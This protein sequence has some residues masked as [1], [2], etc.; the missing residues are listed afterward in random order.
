MKYEL[1]GFWRGGTRLQFFTLLILGAVCIRLAAFKEPPTNPFEG[2]RRFLFVQDV[3]NGQMAAI[4]LHAELVPAAN[5]ALEAADIARA[6]LEDAGAVYDL[7][8][9]LHGTLSQMEGGTRYFALRMPLVLPD[10]GVLNTSAHVMKWKQNETDAEAWVWF[11]TQPVTNVT[12]TFRTTTEWGGFVLLPSVED[13]WPN[14]TMVDGVPCHR[15]V[16]ELPEDL[17]ETVL[18]PPDEIM[19]GGPNGEPFQVPVDGIVV[20]DALGVAH[21]GLTFVET[22]E[23]AF[24]NILETTYHGGM[25][26][27]MRYNGQLLPNG[28]VLK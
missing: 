13:D 10:S 26:T 18:F 2:L 28:S 23:D 11:T 6:A 16:C 1:K 3:Q 21:A 22:E 27:A 15:H 25:V 12:I 5:H 19:L 9:E 4:P 7:A 24:G 17:R 8:T 14:V 20:T